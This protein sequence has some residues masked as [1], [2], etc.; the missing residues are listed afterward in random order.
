L[1]AENRICRDLLA[2]PDLAALVSLPSSQPQ[3]AACLADLEDPLTPDPYAV[4]MIQVTE[5]GPFRGWVTDWEFSEYAER[6]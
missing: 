2:W 6:Q 1:P 3:V 5:L 4:R